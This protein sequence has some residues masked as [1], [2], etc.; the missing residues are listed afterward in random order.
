MA[1]GIAATPQGASAQSQMP[2]FFGSLSGWYYLDAGSNSGGFFDKALNHPDGGPGGKAYLG[3]R[4]NGPFDIAVGG[5]GSRLGKN[6]D[7][8]VGITTTEFSSKAHYWAADA[9]LGYNT[10]AGNAG[11]RLFAGMRFAEFDHLNKQ[12]S[13][14][15]AANTENRY[16][17]VGPR[18][19]TDF[20]ARIGNS[21]FNVFGNAAGSALFGQL[22]EHERSFSNC[23]ECSFS[24]NHSQTVWNA[25]GQLGLGYEVAPGVNVGAGYRAE[26]W[27]HVADREIDTGVG[28]GHDNRLMHGPFIRLAY[29]IGAPRSAPMIAAAPPPQA[30]VP[31]PAAS[32]IVFFD[33]DKS[34]ITAQA[35]ATINDAIAAAKAGN[36]TRV[37]LTGHTDRAG[38]EQYN[39]ALS[40]RRGEAVKAAM[41]RGSIPAAN[42]VVIGRGESAP[43]VPTAD[44]VREPQNR[45]VEI[46]I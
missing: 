44:G 17:G 2:G 16:W 43:L 28:V 36:S 33:F 46:V 32:F 14:M 37:I 15:T 9:E 35:Q 40:V 13:T 23:I 12:S 31:A 10:T 3:Y 41:I 8:F 7:A 11:I 20:T 1:A 6:R 18:V 22:K 5:Q 39:M 24:G 4:F 42:I 38:A 29:N 25:E 21:N 26:Y 45:R 27:N 19:G 34:N 30:P